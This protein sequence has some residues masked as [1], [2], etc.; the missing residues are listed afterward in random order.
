MNSSTTTS[1]RREQIDALSAELA[2]QAALLTR[3]IVRQLDTALSRS[4]ASLLKT[5]TGGPRRISELAELEGLAQPTTTLLVKRLEERGLV[6]RERQPDD[7]RVVIVRVTPDG[8]AALAGFLEQVSATMRAY[9]SDM[10]EEQIDA[11]TVAAGAL[12]N[13]IALLQERGR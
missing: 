6:A 12:D 10:S 9:L 5:L 11:L 8:A 7:G 3:L 13:L 4:E 1:L 2:P